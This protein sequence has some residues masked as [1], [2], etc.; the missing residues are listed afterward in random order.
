[1]STFINCAHINVRSLTAN[2]LNFRDFILN[3][4][5]DVIGV[6]ETR[7]NDKHSSDTFA[8][9]GYNFYRQDRGASGGGIGVYVKSSLKIHVIQTS[10]V[11]EQLWISVSTAKK[12]NSF[13]SYL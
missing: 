9:Y 12:T 1:M 7:L 10:R 2:F 3:K 8:I 5:F 6:T 4:N 13:W 11:I